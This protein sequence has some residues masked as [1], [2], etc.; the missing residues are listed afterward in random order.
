MSKII[1]KNLIGSL[2]VNVTM[3]IALSLL[4]EKLEVISFMLIVIS[5]VLLSVIMCYFLNKGYNINQKD[6][7]KINVLYFSMNFIFYVF[8]FIILRDG[9]IINDIVL[10]AQTLQTEYITVSK[11]SNFSLSFVIF[12]V[13]SYVGHKLVLDRIREK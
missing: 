5:P 13:L 6:K 11:N 1:R 3:I 7:A 10:K 2:F 9:T 8:L 4:K 12:L